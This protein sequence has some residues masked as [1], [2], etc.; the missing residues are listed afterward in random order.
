MFLAE[1]ALN[2]LTCLTEFALTVLMFLTEFVLTGLIWL[3]ELLLTVLMFLTEF[4]LTGLIWLTELALNILTCLT[5]FALTVLMFLTELAQMDSRGAHVVGY[6]SKEKN[7]PEGFN[8]ACILILPPFQ[9]KGYGKFLISLSYEISRREGIPGSPE[10]P[11]SDLGKLSYCSYWT[12]VLLNVLKLH[13]GISVRE[14]TT[15]TGL[16]PPPSLPLPP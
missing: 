10:K 16:Y 4:V 14:L 8:L 13:K 2:I 1:L 7:S 3:T 12:Y 9:K 5:E 15:L 11:L 6:F